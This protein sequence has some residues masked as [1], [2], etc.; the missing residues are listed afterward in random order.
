VG[1]LVKWRMSLA[2]TAARAVRTGGNG[3][4]R[5]VLVVGGGGGGGGFEVI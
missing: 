1:H 2:S 3:V 4:E 5:A